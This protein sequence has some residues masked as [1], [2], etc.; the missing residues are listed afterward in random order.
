VVENFS[1][2]SNQHDWASIWLVPAVGAVGVLILFAFLFRQEDGK[3]AA[4]G[5]GIEPAAAG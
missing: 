1:L 3:S 4:V 5:D 2:T